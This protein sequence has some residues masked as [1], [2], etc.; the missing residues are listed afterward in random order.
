MSH[1][2]RVFEN[3]ARKTAEAIWGMA[4]GECQPEFYTTDPKVRELDGLARL[5]DVSHLI[6]TT[7]SRKLEKTK[8]D[9]R[10]LNAAERIERTRDGGVAVQK[11]FITRDQL[12]AE[13]IR[14]CRDN[15]VTTMTLS[16][17]RRRFFDARSYLAKRRAS[18]FGSARNPDDNSISIPEDE[19]LELPLRVLATE[20][21]VA[22]GDS[23]WSL[24]ELCDQLAQGKTV[25][26]VGPFGAGKS[27]TVR[28][29]FFHLAQRYLSNQTAQAPIA[30]ALREHWG[31][32]YADEI[33]DRH[34]REI[35]F[36]PR[37]DLVA[38]WRAGLAC[39][40]IDGFDEVAAQTVV[41][42]SNRSFM[43]EARFQ[44]LAAARD[45]IGKSPNSS[46]CLITGR[47]HYFDSHKELIY[48]LGLTQRRHTVIELQ[49]FSDEQAEAY[50]QK[51]GSP[52]ALPAW[53]PRK[54]LIL[55][56]LARQTLLT[57]VLAIESDQGFAHAWHRFLNLICEREAAIGT[58]VMDPDTLRHLLERLAWDV[59]STATG[60][61]PITERELAEAYLVETGQNAGEGVLMQLQRLPGLTPREQ[62]PGS[63]AF[64]DVDMLAV[65]QGGALARFVLESRPPGSGRE[66]LDALARRSAEVA[67]YLLR[68]AGSEVSTVVAAAMRPSER[69]STR[70]LAAD[71]VAVALTM[72]ADDTVDCLGVTV[73]EALFRLISVEE[74]R[75]NRL[76]VFDCWIE[77]IAVGPAT[78]QSSIVLSDC[79]IGRLYGASDGSSLPANSFQRCTIEAFDSLGTNAAIVNSDLPPK[80]KALLTVLR[81][82]Y[83][84]AGGGR[85]IAALKRGLPPGEIR[86]SVDGVL[87]V[88]QVHGLVSIFNNIA[89]PER[90]LAARAN[91]IVSARS[92]SEDPIVKEILRR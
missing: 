85:R 66:S 20:Q 48:A 40:L 80:M 17:F 74:R 15:N 89:H 9:V 31:A 91:S 87:D 53:L 44:S 16:D 50:I 65:L 78:L 56:Y 26:L 5:R 54:P 28:E 3:E 34:A 37:E 10:K 42:P 52:S 59:R 83:L 81:K 27:L 19:Y 23:F 58:A 49:E 70:Q 86:D 90:R 45:L 30:L 63:R 41:S 13:H 4:P 46:G 79:V 22:Q 24:A 71:C 36:M 8:E 12:E 32:K 88:L 64:V 82:L 35:G 57:Q 6:M 67:G 33:L 7:V 1:E 68:S 14:H 75:I 61:G 2:D 92:L 25:V 73:R 77:E 60:T 55:A 38:A 11:W 62:D 29:V 18:A 72:S 76:N 51:K 69:A 43:R 47:N 39:L 84:Q 21:G